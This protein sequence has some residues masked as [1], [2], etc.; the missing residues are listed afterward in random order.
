MKTEGPMRLNLDEISIAQKVSFSW[1]TDYANEE[2]IHPGAIDRF[3]IFAVYQ[4]WTVWVLFVVV[5][6]IVDAEVLFRHHVAVDDR[7]A[8]PEQSDKT[9]TGNLC[10]YH[11]SASRP[12]RIS[13]PGNIGNCSMMED[14]TE[15]EF[16]N[17]V[18]SIP[19]CW[20]MPASSVFSRTRAAIDSERGRIVSSV[21]ISTTLVVLD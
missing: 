10:S 19:F 9:G 20:L 14:Q 18:R 17:R 8:S 1:A 21:F 12:M 7:K 2:V 5:D 4:R 16:G 3:K 13:S 11:L 15:S 6:D